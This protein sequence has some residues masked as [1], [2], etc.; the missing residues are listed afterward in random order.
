MTAR[1][2]GM[3]DDA[4]CSPRSRPHSEQ[5]NWRPAEPLEAYVSN[6]REWLEQ[7]DRRAV[8]LLGTAR[9]DLWRTRMV[10]A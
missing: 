5:P 2:C 3:S 6:F 8:T 1:G 10:R 9:I 4:R 7:S